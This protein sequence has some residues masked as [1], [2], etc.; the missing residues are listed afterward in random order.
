MQGLLGLD[1]ANQSEM[2][3]HLMTP[4]MDKGLRNRRN[5]SYKLLGNDSTAA[6]SY[7][8]LDSEVGAAA[9]ANQVAK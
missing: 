2:A 9:T 6:S 1:D 5:K 8:G 3:S 7:E 4:Q